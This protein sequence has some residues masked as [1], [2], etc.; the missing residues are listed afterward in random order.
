VF[1]REKIIGLILVFWIMLNVGF[2][3]F[4]IA[5]ASQMRYFIPSIA[6]LIILFIAGV[7]KLYES[8]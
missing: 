3:V 8:R 5:A 4:F 7:T 1:R 2:Y 6:P